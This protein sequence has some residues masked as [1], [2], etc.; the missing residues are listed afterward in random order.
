MKEMMD[1]VEHRFDNVKNGNHKEHYNI[2]SS[3]DSAPPTDEKFTKKLHNL[4][5]IAENSSSAKQ[6]KISMKA[7]EMLI[8]SKAVGNSS[9]AGVDRFFICVHFSPS[10]EQ[11]DADPH[12]H[13]ENMFFSRF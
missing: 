11:A 2:K 7:R 8:K 6:R 12:H 13:I 1:A 9:I 10:M 5:R 3:A 4:D